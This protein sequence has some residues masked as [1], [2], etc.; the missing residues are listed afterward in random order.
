VK[1]ILNGNDLELERAVRGGDK[2]LLY[3]INAVHFLVS[4]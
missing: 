1:S 2:L 4:S 3:V